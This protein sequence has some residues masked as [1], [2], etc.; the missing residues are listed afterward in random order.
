MAAP[1]GHGFVGMAIARRMGVRSPFA[2]AAAFVA[3]S[4][5]DIDIPIGAIIG[6][7]IHRT[8]THTP[9][10]ALTAGMLAGMTGILG[11]E[12]VEGER[13]LIY[14]ALVGAAVVGS[15][16]ILDHSPYVPKIPIGP[17]LLGMPLI[18]WAID[19]AQWAVVA[20][21]IWPKAAKD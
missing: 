2:L 4:F 3:A 5:P 17:K 20:Y 12:S 11:A 21:L 14:D 15:H 8:A 16:V 1:L 10:F 13:D 7:D 18:N 19:S 6:K 9:N